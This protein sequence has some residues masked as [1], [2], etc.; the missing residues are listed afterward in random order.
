MKC[1]I[2]VDGLSFLV[3]ITTNYAFSFSSTCIE[4]KIFE[5]LSNFGTFLD[6]CR[7]ENPE[8]KD[9]SFPNPKDDSHQISKELIK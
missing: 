6:P 8:I 1:T 2:L 9:I 5:N 7:S 3:Y 4:V